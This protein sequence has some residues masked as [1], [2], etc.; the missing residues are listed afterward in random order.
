MKANTLQIEINHSN[1]INFA[2]VNTYKVYQ[3]K[4][5]NKLYK[6]VRL[7]ESVTSN[8]DNNG[9]SFGVAKKLSEKLKKNLQSLEI[10]C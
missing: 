3:I 10:K 1:E 4:K 7:L 8:I 2:N 5:Q 9:S 6:K